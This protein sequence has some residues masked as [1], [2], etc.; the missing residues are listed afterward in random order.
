MDNGF[1]DSAA[2]EKILTAPIKDIMENSIAGEMDI[3]PGDILYSINGNEINDIIDYE[4]YSQ[5]DNLL[6]KIEKAN[7]GELWILEI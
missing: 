6:V 1:Q 4:F 7:S 5:E 3:E 2:E